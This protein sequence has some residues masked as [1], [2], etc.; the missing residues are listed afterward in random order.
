M[1]D[2]EFDFTPRYEDLG[3]DRIF[4]AVD[5]TAQQEFVLERAIITAANNHAELYMGHVV[6]SS[7]LETAGSY[8]QGLL[9]NLEDSFYEQ[10]APQLDEALELVAKEQIGKAEVIVRIGRVRETLREMLDEIKPDLI[11]CG[12][13]GLSPLKHALLGSVSTYLMR[14]ADCDV[15]VLK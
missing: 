8:P 4:V 13:R 9:Q 2:R 7:T 15:L 6:D 5:G 12:A 10:I 3:Y 1:S 11:I 14:V